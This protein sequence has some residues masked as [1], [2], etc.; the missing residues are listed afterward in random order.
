[1][2]SVREDMAKT[3]WLNEYNRTEVLVPVSWEEL[4]EWAANVYLQLADAILSHPRIAILAK[5]QS[6][7]INH[8]SD[9]P[10]SEGYPRYQAV[11]LMQQ[12][13]LLSN[14]KRIEE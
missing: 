4:P 1:M 14:F 10:R 12:R 6:L 9:R 13:M 7:P 11:H 5:D 8:Y 3:I 2:S